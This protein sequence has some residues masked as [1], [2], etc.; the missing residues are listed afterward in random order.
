MKNIAKIL[1]AIL[2]SANLAIAEGLFFGIEGSYSSKE[3]LTFQEDIF[4]ES[5]ELS[6]SNQAFGFKFGKDESIYRFYGQFNV[7]S[8][9]EN[10]NEWK[11]IIKS[12][13]TSELL[14]GIDWTPSVSK[15]FN[16]MLGFYSGFSFVNIDADKI[17]WD[18][19]G[20][21][22]V[23][24]YE[25]DPTAVNFMGLFGAKFGGIFSFDEHSVIELGIKGDYA[26]RLTSSKKPF[27]NSEEITGKVS[28]SKMSFFAGY[29][30]KF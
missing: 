10:N 15:N 24:K 5:I 12:W 4:P 28:D 16:L 21:F 27:S 8:Q 17:T 25:Y 30:F 7:N 19:G 29:T 6:T 18:D 2:F 13:Q 11:N 14:F 1:A 22:I 3:T 20:S 23:T 26:F 9:K